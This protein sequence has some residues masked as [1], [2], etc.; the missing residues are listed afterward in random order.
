M[1]YDT[2]LLAAAVMPLVHYAAAQANDLPWRGDADPYHIWVSEI[3]LQQTRIA[4]VIPYYDRFLQAFPTVAALAASPDDRLMKAWEGLGYYSRARNLKKAALVL[5]QEYDGCL[6]QEVDALRRLPGIGA[7][8]AGAIASIA[9]GR[10]EP[11]VDGNVLRVV[12]RL[13]ACGDDVLKEST[14][15][16]VAAALRA[17]YP[18]GR[19]AT[20]LTEGLMLLGERVCVSSGEVH[21]QICPLRSL[22]RAKAGEIV[23]LFPVRSP[24]KPRRVEARTVLLLRMD[25]T[26]A[27]RKRPSVGLLAALYEFPNLDGHLSEEDVRSYLTVRGAEVLSVRSCGAARHIFSHVEWDMTGYEVCLQAPPAMD[28]LAFYAC[29]Q[30]LTSFAIPTAFRHYTAQL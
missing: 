30:L 11:A 2:E 21:C 29:D 27:V 25:N 17:V 13:L 8:T 1:P 22:C 12:M 24:K 6:P 23:S 18:T 16:A 28:G 3:M 4:A 10:P 20:L 5:M 26:V 7:Y 14:K 9:Y 15:G 19:D